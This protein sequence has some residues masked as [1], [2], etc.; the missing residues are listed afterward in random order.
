MNLSQKML[1]TLLL[2]LACIFASQIAMR[3]LVEL[4]VLI[5]LEAQSDRKDVER[6]Q[7]ALQERLRE[8][9]NALFDY[10]AWDD[11][12]K[13]MS[14]SPSDDF[15]QHY[16]VANFDATVF[17]GFNI[18]GVLLLDTMNQ[19]VYSTHFDSLTGK[20]EATGHL[21]YDSLDPTSLKQNPGYSN[22]PIINAGISISNV[23]P[24]LFGASEIVRSIEPYG[25]SRGTFIYWTKLD[26][27]FINS[28]S[29]ILKIEFDIIPV[30]TIRDKPELSAKME[31]LIREGYDFLPRD[32]QSNLYWLI[33][34]I[35]GDPLFLVRQKAEMRKFNDAWLSKSLIMGFSV[36]GLVLIIISVLFSRNVIYRLTLAK[37]IMNDIINTG[38]YANRLVV[39]GNDQIDMMFKQFN[40]LLR[41]IEG[42]ELK[43]KKQNSELEKLNKEDALTGIGNRRHLDEILGRCWRQC[44]RS[45]KPISVLMIDVDCFKG[46][47][48]HYGHQYGDLAL[49]DIARTLQENLHRASDHLARYGGEEFSVVLLYTDKEEAFCVANRLRESVEVMQIEHETSTCSSV[50]TVSIGVATVIPEAQN[51]EI[52]LLKSADHALYQAK[53]N[54][55]NKVCFFDR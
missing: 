33:S 34:D 44:M 5:E 15:F 1:V 50:V 18:E 36:S 3:D 29:E 6:I 16:V 25:E 43:L 28:L 40:Q 47:N 2:S 26:S 42:Q 11:T 24:V 17:I 27:V 53:K 37:W 20:I 14:L 55:R 32:E 48:D 38:D 46:Y 45:G 41:Y 19:V 52:D 35:S 21:I 51:T 8:H 31:S 10:A 23:G 7:V 30:E 12:Y 22:S 49:K 39:K 54:G 4:P 9:I 13:L